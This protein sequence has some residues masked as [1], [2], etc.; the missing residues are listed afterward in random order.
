MNTKNLPLFVG[1]TL[2]VLFIALIS[3]AVYIPRLSLHPQ[4]N[5]VYTPAYWS[6]YDVQNDYKITDGHLV[7]TPNSLPKDVKQPAKVAPDLY[8]YDIQNNTSHQ[9]TFEEA[10]KYTFT[11]GPSSPDGYVVGFKNG[12]A[13]IFEL[14]GSSGDYNAVYISKN[15][16][17]KKLDAIASDAYGYRGGFR[18]I[19]WIQ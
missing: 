7:M 1:I 11:A 2:P 18:F 14:F 6:T 17:G 15:G 3:V 10:Q 12:N 5:F 16:A 9:I 19:G 13:G 4:Y 8:L